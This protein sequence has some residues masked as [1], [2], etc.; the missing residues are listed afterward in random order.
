MRIIFIAAY[1]I[2]LIFIG[3]YSRK[4]CKN[5][6][7]FFV[8]DRR[9]GLLSLSFTLSATVI[10]SSAVIIAGI[11]VLNYGL[12]GLWIDLSGGLGLILLALFLARKVRAMAFYTLPQIVEGMYGRRVAF[13]ASIFVIFAEVAWLALIM[14][15]TQAVLST[16]L[17]LAPKLLLL[18]VTGIFILY[19]YLGG[20]YAVAYSDIFQ[21]AIMIGGICFLAAPL[22]YYYSGG[23][24][25][26]PQQLLSFPT[27]PKFGVLD[28]L[29]IFFMIGLSHI[30]GSDIYAKILSAKS[31]RTASK[32]AF[33]AGL[34]KIVFGIAIAIIALSALKITLHLKSPESLIP[35]M[36]FKVVPFP[37]DAL[38]IV[39]LLATLM[40]SADS[41]LLTASTVFSND[42]LRPID[43][44]RLL[45][46]GQISVLVFGGISLII[47]LYSPGLIYT[48]RL[49][50]S[51]FVAGLIIPIICGFYQKQLKVNSA[52]AV[53]SMIGGGSITLI[54][55]LLHY[56]YSILFGL[57]ISI[58]LLFLS[59]FLMKRGKIEK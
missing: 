39:A 32:G 7:S 9:L 56:Q 53:A 19:T 43:D 50:Y 48:F 17:P 22:A 16:F 51:V 8:A 30:V 37:L 20:Q 33:L 12:A 57:G 54:G 10:G 49:G 45:Q 11:Y 31:E 35:E 18:I 55:N 26:L 21:F 24:S 29:S 58:L 46:G 4:R 34:F 3:I 47:A 27:S 15:S 13:I 14:Q 41:I 40:S 52:G 1:L 23:L 38:V 42:I 6:A 44:R 59:S 5:P 36:I 25:T 2:V 28:L